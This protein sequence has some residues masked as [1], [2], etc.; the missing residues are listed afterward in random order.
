MP[1]FSDSRLAHPDDEALG[2]FAPVLHVY[3]LPESFDAKDTVDPCAEAAH[4]AS[5]GSLYKWIPCAVQAGHFDQETDL[6]PRFPSLA[7]GKSPQRGDFGVSAGIVLYWQRTMQVTKVTR[8]TWDTYCATVCVCQ[9]ERTL[10]CPTSRARRACG[11]CARTARPLWARIHSETALS[12]HRA[13]T[14]HVTLRPETR[15][16]RSTDIW[17]RQ[18]RTWLCRAAAKQDAVA[19][20]LAARCQ[21]RGLPYAVVSIKVIRVSAEQRIH[22]MAQRW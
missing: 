20:D 3:Q 21:R 14:A 15:N 10:G 17:R 22:T 8:L 4:V 18:A 2:S 9:L 16:T 13:G 11:A 12:G 7:D 19:A 5:I 6:G 1:V